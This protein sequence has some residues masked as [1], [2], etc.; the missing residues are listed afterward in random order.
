MIRFLWL[1]LSLCSWAYLYA[2]TPAWQGWWIWLPAFG[3]LLVYLYGWVLEQ[4]NQVLVFF[5]GLLWCGS[6]LSLN[7]YAWL[8]SQSRMP[9]SAIMGLHAMLIMVLLTS[10]FLTVVN[11]CIQHNFMNRRGNVSK[12]QL[13]VVKPTVSDRWTSIKRVFIRNKSTEIQLNLGEEIPMKE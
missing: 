1:V 9:I 5:T 3:S 10:L 4:R 7:G 11:Y 13:V 12:Q 2:Q 6:A 8:M